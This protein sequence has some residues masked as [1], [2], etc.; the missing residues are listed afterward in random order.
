MIFQT[1][2][3]ANSPLD[4]RNYT[5][6]ISHQDVKFIVKVKQSEKQKD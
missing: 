4:C 1:I 6:Q 5:F 3:V 2:F